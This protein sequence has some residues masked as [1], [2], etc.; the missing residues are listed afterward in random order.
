MKLIFLKE[1]N[2]FICQNC[3][4]E[5]PVPENDDLCPFCYSYNITHKEP[6]DVELHY[7]DNFYGKTKSTSYSRRDNYPIPDCKCF[8]IAMNSCYGS[9]GYWDGKTCNPD[10]NHATIFA[11]RNEAGKKIKFSKMNNYCDPVIEEVK[12]INNEII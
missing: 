11:T 10:K 3:G 8:V 4:E 12:L 7:V 6:E 2:L 1:D 5:F 9:S